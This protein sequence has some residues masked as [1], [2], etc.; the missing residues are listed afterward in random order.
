MSHEHNIRTQRTARYFTS[1]EASEKITTCWIVLHGYAQSAEE[2]ILPF[3]HLH[4]ENTLIVAPEGLSR[5]YKKSYN[6]VVASWMTRAQR[7]GEVEDYTTY[8]SSVYRQIIPKCAQDVQIIVVGFS[9]GSTTLTRWIAA[10]KPHFHHAIIWGWT[11]P[12]DIDYPKLAKY[13]KN[14]Q[15]WLVCGDADP[16]V[17]REAWAKNID[18][19]TK[20]A[21]PFQEISLEGAK[22]EVLPPLVD[23]IKTTIATA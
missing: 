18:F 22:H 5:F 21:L 3:A 16:L 19:A 11:L 15:L 14:K 10:K 1:G 20:Q 8:L 13:L 7:L 2:F 9:Q 6:E 23:T 4:N 12:E 17:S